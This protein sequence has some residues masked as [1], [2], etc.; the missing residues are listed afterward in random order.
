MLQAMKQIFKTAL[1]FCLLAAPSQAATLWQTHSHGNDVWLINT[2]TGQVIDKIITGAN[3][4]G[5]AATADGRIVFVANEANDAEKGDLVWIDAQSRQITKRVELC[6]EPHAIAATPDGKWIYVPCRDE[7]YKVVDG[8][9]GTVVRE[10]HTGGR[11]HNTQISDNGHFAYLSPMEEPNKVTI[12]DIKGGHKVHGTLPFSDGVRPPALSNKNGLFF[13]HV[14]GLNG[15]EVADIETRQNIARIKHSRPLPGVMIMPK[16]GWFDLSGFNRCHGLAL[17]P[18][19]REVWS[20][21]ADI[22]SIHSTSAPFAEKAR[23][24]LPAKGYWL[25][26]GP[27]HAFIA[28]AENNQVAQI[29]TT[30]CSIVRLINVG[31]APKRNLVLEN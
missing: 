16:L 17:T 23:I 18:D 3:P 25:T 19:E 6:R 21:C 24:K 5:I 31:Q 14:D 26:F 10:I 1:A 4:H 22:L 20:V 13:Q 28:L 9:T 8:E 2:D 29:K 27:A 15:F 11:P 30:T 7:T 12:I